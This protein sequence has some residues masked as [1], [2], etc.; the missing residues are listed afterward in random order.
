MYDLGTLRRYA[1]GYLANLRSLCVRTL[2]PFYSASHLGSGKHV[3]QI[4][5]PRVRY[6]KASYLQSWL[7][8]PGCKFL[9]AG[10][11]PLERQVRYFF[12]VQEAAMEFRVIWE[13]E[14][15]AE[16][17]REAAQQARAIQLI[18]GMSATAF[19]VWAYAAGKMH[20]I[21]LVEEPGRLDREE[22]FALIFLEK[23]NILSKEGA[24]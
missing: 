17:P 6:Y 1:V 18:P 7:L 10:P 19:D 9:L 22:L 14:I 16:G 5:T 8:L 24:S 11:W 23:D 20:R 13:I 12:Q 4:E 2:T 15:E 3:L 21:D